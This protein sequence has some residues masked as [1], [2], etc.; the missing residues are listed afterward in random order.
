MPVQ[1]NNRGPIIPPGS[2][3]VTPDPNR[4]RIRLGLMVLGGLVCFSAMAIG[5]QGCHSSSQGQSAAL[6]NGPTN[7]LPVFETPGNAPVS[8]EASGSAAAPTANQQAPTSVTPVHHAAR[9]SGKEYT[10]AKGDSFEIVAH[11]FHVPLKALEE[12]NPGLNPK[13]LQIG[14]VLLI[15][16]AATNTVGGRT[17]TSQ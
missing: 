10:V 7:P 1:L 6:Q 11:K 8:T 16:A 9:L 17:F 15:P 4:S 14:Q 12:A 13:R 5:F 3:L 2:P